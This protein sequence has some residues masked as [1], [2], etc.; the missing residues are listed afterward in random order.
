MIA[1]VLLPVNSLRLRISG[2]WLI[3]IHHPRPGLQVV[4]PQIELFR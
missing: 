1:H 2:G 3:V 4:G